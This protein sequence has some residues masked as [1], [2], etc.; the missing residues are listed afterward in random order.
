VY[1]SLS[2][3][4]AAVY[5]LFESKMRADSAAKK[6]EKSGT[7]AVVTSTLTRRQYWKKLLAI[8]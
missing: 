2:G 4:G 3:S 8:S 6:L 1:A 7:R 5:G